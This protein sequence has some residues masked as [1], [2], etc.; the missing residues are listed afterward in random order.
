MKK[1]LIA[2][3][4]A[5]SSAMSVTAFAASD[6]DV[7]GTST[8]TLDIEV[9]V[10]DSVRISGLDDFTATFDGANDVIHT[11]QAC[12]YRN[13]S[14]AYGV[15][16]TG[17]G[18]SNAFTIEDGPTIIDYAVSWNNTDITIPGAL[19]SGQSGADDSS[20]TCSGGTNATLVL[21]VAA[22]DLLAAPASVLQGTLTVT[23]SP[24]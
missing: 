1:L 17:D 24:E 6:G 20:T 11:D 18:A 10:E 22:A 3:A 9:T 2:S 4:I 15:S 16:A 21:T 12:I 13:G 14:D 19:L 5:A 7:G 23:V 8:G